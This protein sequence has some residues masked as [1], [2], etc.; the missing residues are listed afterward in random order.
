MRVIRSHIY[1]AVPDFEIMPTI[2][3]V[4]CL[5]RIKK[6]SEDQFMAIRTS[7]YFLIAPNCS[8]MRPNFLD[9][10]EDV[11]KQAQNIRQN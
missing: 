9:V 2:A 1:D 10:N 7:H 6:F 3:A 11:W 5:A 4:R 8:R